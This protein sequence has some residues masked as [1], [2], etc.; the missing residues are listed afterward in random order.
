M[1]DLKIPQM[2]WYVEI[3]R[4]GYTRQA[5]FVNYQDAVLFV[6]TLQSE[7]GDDQI[8]E[9]HIQRIKP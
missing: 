3:R 7:Y 5:A 1:S 4:Q 6:Y 2:N 9:V 8:S